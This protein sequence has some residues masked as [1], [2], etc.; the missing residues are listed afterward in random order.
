MDPK[1]EAQRQRTLKGIA[2]Y[3][4]EQ[5]RILGAIKVHDNALNQ[6]DFDKIFGGDKTVNK[7]HIWNLAPE[8]FLLGD[9]SYGDLSKYIHLTQF[10]IQVGKVET[11]VNSGG[12]IVYSAPILHKEVN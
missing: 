5:D 1:Q 10:M 8:G 9:L 7:V 4:I 3:Q 6:D 11:T 2:P 12:R